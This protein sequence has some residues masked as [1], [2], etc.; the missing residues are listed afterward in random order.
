MKPITTARTIDAPLDE[1][2]HV[3][4]DIAHF[5]QA[6]PQ[7]TKVEFLTDQRSGIGT[8]FRE[9]RLMSGREQQV[10]LEVTEYVPSDRVRLVADAGGT[11]WDTLF[12]VTPAGAQTKLAMAMEARA[13]RLLA[14]I[15]NPLI[16]RMVVKGV[17]RD[18][19]A[20]KEYCERAT[21]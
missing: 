21:G 13:Y 18:M 3:V 12:T 15:M 5:S 10:E 6:V 11:I 8:R 7:I 20:V 4:A 16:R 17:E 19:D 2:F 9:T 1:V 14:K